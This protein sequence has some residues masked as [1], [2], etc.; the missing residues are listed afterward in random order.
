MTKNEKSAICRV[1]FDLIQADSIIDSGE[2]EK[3]SVLLEKYAINQEDE[4]AASQITFADA[5]NTISLM[6]DVIK[7][8]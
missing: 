1:L 5:V 3:Y 7:D 8:S 4:I 6:D 2:M